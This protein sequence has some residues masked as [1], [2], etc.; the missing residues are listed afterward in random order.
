M[1]V[2]S[3]GF[4]PPRLGCYVGG[5]LDMGIKFLVRIVSGKSSADVS[6]V[7][8]ALQDQSFVLSGFKILTLER[9]ASDIASRSSIRARVGLRPSTVKAERSTQDMTRPRRLHTAVRRGPRGLGLRDLGR[10]LNGLRA[11]QV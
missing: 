3:A 10:K 5:S 11:F 4:E 6:R 1:P 8:Y 9:D 7:G 2:E